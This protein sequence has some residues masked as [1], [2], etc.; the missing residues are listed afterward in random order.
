[1]EMKREKTLAEV[2]ESPRF[3]SVYVDESQVPEI[4]SWKVGESY[5]LKNMRVKMSR[6]EISE[7]DGKKGITAYLELLEY[8]AKQDKKLSD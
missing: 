1:M 2:P 8:D 3:P 7:H 5:D 6:R 4:G